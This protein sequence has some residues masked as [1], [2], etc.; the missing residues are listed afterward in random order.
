MK[1]QIL[2]YLSVLIFM[3]IFLTGCMSYTTL[4]SSKTLE[5]GQVI[6]GGGISESGTIR[7]EVNSRV[8]VVKRFDVGAKIEAGPL[9]FVDGKYQILQGPINVSADL[10]WAYFS[11][12]GD[13]GQDKGKFT[14]WYPMLMVGQDHWYIALKEVYFSAQSDFELF[15][16]WKF[17]GSGW[18]STN[19]TAGAIVG[20]K[21]RFLPEMNLIISRGGSA[22]IVPAIGLQFI[23]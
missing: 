21:V 7:S 19:I 13:F 22:V 20:E 4:Q 17:K 14:S 9:Y 10:G 23:L 18:I 3:L 11:Y 2:F 12:D 16:A 8:G 15:G 6:I 5:P 1:K